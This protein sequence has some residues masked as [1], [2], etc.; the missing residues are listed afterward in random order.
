MQNT[1]ANR[2]AFDLDCP[3][4]NIIIVNTGGYSFGAI[5][6]NKKATYTCKKNTACFLDSHSDENV[7]VIRA[8]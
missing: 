6:C 1:V 7:K 5:G 8:R 4:N 2:A 3:E